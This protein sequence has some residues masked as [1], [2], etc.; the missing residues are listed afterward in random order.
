MKYRLDRPWLGWRRLGLLALGV[1]G[2]AGAGQADTL[3]ARASLEAR[4]DAVRQAWQAE[5]PAPTT[6][7]DLADTQQAPPW[8]NWNN[9]SNWPN[10][11][12]WANWLN[13]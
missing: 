9:W 6:E 12:N 4:V 10:W 5:A 1:L 7:R 3:P 8:N 13:R 2:L 11:G